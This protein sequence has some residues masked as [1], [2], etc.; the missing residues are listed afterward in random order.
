LSTPQE[1]INCSKSSTKSL[2]FNLQGD[3]HCGLASFPKE[4]E[5]DNFEVYH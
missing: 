3:W 1:E 2:G 4:E 5:E